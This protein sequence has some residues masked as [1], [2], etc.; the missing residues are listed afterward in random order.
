[1]RKKIHLQLILIGVMAILLTL[2]LSSV[3]YYDLF[4]KEVMDSLK[5][6]TYV[7]KT[8]G[9]FEKDTIRYAEDKDGLRITIINADG[10]V[11]FESN[12]STDIMDN[13]KTRPEIVAAF[14]KGEGEAVRR[15][16]TL[17][18][19]TFYYAVK[20]DNGQVL[21]VAKDAGSIWKFYKTI[22]PVLVLLVVVLIGIC[23]MLARILT[24]SIVKPIEQMAQH[25]GEPEYEVEYQELKPFM[26]T[27]QK[28]HEDIVKNS[29]MRQVFTANISHELKTPLT[30]ISGYSE[31][32]ANGM[33]N[34]EDTKRFAGE[35]HNSSKRLV[36]LINDSIR[37]SELDFSEQEVQMEPVDLYEIAGSCVDMLQISA[38]K[39]NVSLVMTG[40]A[41]TIRANR[42]MMMEL[43]Y[44]L[45]DNAIRYNVPGGS[46]TV[47]VYQEREHGVL[48]VEDTGIGIPQE[49][50]EHIFERFYRV[51]K[52]RSKSTGGTGL[53]LAIVK[54]MVASHHAALELESKVGEGTTF[55]IY[56]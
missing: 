25:L 35:I 18:T 28:Q 54:H 20:L 21:R 32:I 55:R 27:I 29:N 46:V 40:N 2:G 7:F 1:M 11:N 22:I 19:N 41:C 30:A 43:V 16:T 15:S 4:K 6:Y 13:H 49:E 38:K 26:T 42:E 56:F 39:H 37:L 51:D 47:S 53:G 48:V 5:S 3:V 14:E 24:R 34:E 36:T 23:V 44:N 17:E 45:C 50:Q 10:S 31:L 12:A 8:A 9:F 52:G 33:T